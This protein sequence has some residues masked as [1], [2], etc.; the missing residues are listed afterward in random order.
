MPTG[1]IILLGAFAGLTIYLGLPLAFLKYTPQSLKIFLNMLATGV[2][3]FLLY[4][5]ISK[6]SDGDHIGGALDQLRIHHTGLGEFLLDIA[7]F[8]LGIG[9]GSVGLVYFNRYVFGRVRKTAETSTVVA[10][11]NT[12][13]ED[14]ASARFSAARAS[15]RRYV[16]S[17]S[18]QQECGE[19]PLILRG[20]SSSSA[21][22]I[23]S[24]ASWIGSNQVKRAVKHHRTRSCR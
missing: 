11:D 17:C 10:V 21:N 24:T 6:A 3:F 22:S 1:T 5:V 18:R 14:V 15:I 20:S 4:D 16:P 19:I 13:S 2:L 7:L 23:V 8:A 12:P 9:L